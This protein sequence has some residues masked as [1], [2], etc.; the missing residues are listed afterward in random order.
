[1]SNLP[2]DS[3]TVIAATGGT[4][5]WGLQEHLT[6]ATV[7]LLAAA[8]WQRGGGKGV[9]PKPLKRPGV[10]DGDV[11]RIGGSRTYSV[12]EMR[13]LLDLSRTGTD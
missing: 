7:D 8:N 13:E 12:D 9:Q 5:L 3:A 1:M 10:N 11:E 6:A 2:P 4:S